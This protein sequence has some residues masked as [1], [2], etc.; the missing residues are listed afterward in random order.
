MRDFLGFK[1]R[2]IL[3]LYWIPFDAVVVFR[4]EHDFLFKSDSTYCDCLV[5]CTQYTLHNVILIL[6]VRYQSF[7]CMYIFFVTSGLC[8]RM[9]SCFQLVSCTLYIYRYR[10]S[11]AIFPTFCRFFSMHLKLIGFHDNNF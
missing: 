3:N 4:P 9:L 6:S 1:F 8:F 10:Q 5:Y 2:A 7:G 11:R